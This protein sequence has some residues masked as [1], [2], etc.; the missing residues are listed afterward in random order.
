MQNHTIVYFTE[1]VLHD[2][3]A[4]MNGKGR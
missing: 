3:W 1:M 4:T 2:R